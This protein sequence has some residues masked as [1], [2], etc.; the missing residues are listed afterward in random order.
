M[1]GESGVVEPT[2]VKSPLYEKEGV[3]WFASNVEL[4]TEGVKNIHPVGSMS[5]EEEELLKACLPEYVNSP[6]IWK[7]ANDKLEEEHPEGC[8]VRHQGISFDVSRL[9]LLWMHMSSN[10]VCGFSST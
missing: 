10:A 3:E 2:F 9:K 8:R 5:A 6:L 7:C 1:N 4:G